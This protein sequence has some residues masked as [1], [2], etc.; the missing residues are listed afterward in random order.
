M[1]FLFICR[2]LPD[3][4][5]LTFIRRNSGPTVRKT[6]FV[7]PT[8]IRKLFEV[9]DMDDTPLD[10]E[11]LT[12]LNAALAQKCAD[13]DLVIVC[14]FGHGMIGPETVRLL[15]ELPVFVAVNTQSN[16]GN[17]GF[18]LAAKHGGANFLCIDAMEARLVARDKHAPVE[19][20]TR[21]VK[22]MLSDCPNLIVTSGKRGCFAA[23]KQDG[24]ITH[25]PSFGITAVDTVGAGDA[26]FVIAAPFLA[27][28]ADLETAGIMGNIAGAIKIGIVG[29]RRYL[30]KLEVQ[31]YLIS[32]LK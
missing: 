19:K 26:F 32:L 5:D 11:P 17:I 13:A 6:R 9:Y 31:R 10:G 20:I 30:E 8:Y 7:E 21:H 28:G 29:H 4:V 22:D 12:N 14:D 2:S 18:N 25:I 23:D 16:A 24:E 27:A 1:R 3:G 15:E